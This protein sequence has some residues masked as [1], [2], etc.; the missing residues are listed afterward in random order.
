LH[1]YGRSRWL[2]PSGIKDHRGV[3]RIIDRPSGQL[4]T[5]QFLLV[6]LLGA[7]DVGVVWI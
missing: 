3:L 7:I 1:G 6:K 2:R 5:L 4:Q